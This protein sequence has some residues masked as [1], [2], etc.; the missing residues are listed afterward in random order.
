MT[1]TQSDS[2]LAPARPTAEVD[3]DVL[4]VGMGPMG[5]A[6]ALALADMGVKVRMIT[7]FPWL[8]NTPRAHIV[9]QR[10]MEVLRDLGVE[11]DI[12]RVGTPWELMG[13]CI[14]ATS[15]TG[16]EIVRMPSWG[17]GDER[18]GEYARHSPCTYLDVPQPRFEPV[19]VG[20]AAAR[21]VQL[22]FSTELLSLQQYPDHVEAVLV[23]RTSGVE[24]VVR[25][26]YLVGADGARSRVAEQVGLPLEGH[27]ARSG[28]VYTEFRADLT[29]LVAHRPSILHYFFNPEVGYGEIG[30]GLLRAVK[31]WT[32]WIAGWGFDP[33]TGDPD[34][35]VDAVTRRIRL[36]IGD[37]DIPIEVTRSSPWY[38]NQQTTATYSVG[39][40][41][42]GGDATHRHP[43][44]SGLGLNTSV[45][46][47][48]N[49]AWKLAYVLRG[50]AG[51]EL[52]DSYTAERAPVG[53]QIVLRANQSRHDFQV[54]RD[55]FVT[56][57]DG[58]PV[59]NVVANLQAPTPEGVE[60][61]ALLER[62]LRVKDDEWNAEG[63]EKDIN[64]DSGAVIP[65][66]TALPIDPSPLWYVPSTRP[67]AK[68]PHAWLTDRY[69]HRLST[70]DV[71]GKGRFT[72]LTGVAGVAWEEAAARLGHEWLEVARIGVSDLADPY[73]AW[74]RVRGTHEAGAVL[75]RPDGYISWRHTDPQ[76]D[77][78]A[79]ES[80]LSDAID[81]VLSRST[82]RTNPGDLVLDRS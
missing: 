72:L 45:Q 5:S 14:V 37:E 43:P 3:V 74:A 56:E 17:T 8:A 27:K 39:R 11:E 12:R 64:Y 20:A 53:K 76:W 77:V 68:L 42:C 34:M 18:H 55:C 70:L 7:M 63:V 16:T 67:G 28:H 61:R 62:A 49:L 30:L 10:A 32:E 36:L 48:H 38:V 24:S 60:L 6:T 65:D 66:G 80:A 31:P 46:D 75:V 35:S 52:L 2:E 57:G 40:V 82:A 78:D 81:R 59:E 47:A 79:A 54:L 19:V 44:S 73:A 25:C 22:S 41:F 1:M 26:R 15:L 13:D 69:G 58:T 23:D 4:V 71:V 51:Q 9:S 29:H 21:G 50:E 33:T